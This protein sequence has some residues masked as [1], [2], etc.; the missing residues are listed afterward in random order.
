[1][2]GTTTVA[3]LSRRTYETLN[4][5]VYHAR[6]ANGLRLYVI[7]KPD[8]NEKYAVFA[9]R[10]GSIDTSFIPPGEEQVV[11]TPPGVA[12]FLE[13]KLFEGEDGSVFEQFAAL[14][15]S[16]NAYTTYGL[17][18]YL[19]STTDHFYQCLKTLVDFVQH[20]YFTDEN[21]AKE[22]GIIA[23]EIT[24]YEDN[25]NAQV[26]NNLLQAMYHHHPVRE[27]ITGSVQSVAGI[28][29]EILYQCHST[30]YH[31]ENMILFAIGNIDPEKAA[32]VV[33]NCFRADGQRVQGTIRRV[34]PSEPQGVK[35]S[36]I[37]AKMS[38]ARPLCYLGFK[39]AEL[40]S[41]DE[42]LKRQLATSLSLQILFGKTSALYNR[43]YESGLIDNSFSAYYTAEETFAYSILGGVTPDPVRLEEAVL[44]GLREARENGMTEEEFQRQKRKSIGGFL[45]ALNSLDFIA[46][47]F[48]ST[49][50]RGSSLFSYLD[51]LQE[52]KVE[53]VERCVEEQLTEERLSVSIIWPRP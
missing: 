33:E 23:Q 48:V 47:N 41:G 30:F 50:F 43:L 53:D 19:F 8:Y 36:R 32:Q 15:A 35:E 44:A 2:K 1:M 45:Y 6:L 39:D 24:M 51:I 42:L 46:N 31:P 52:L 38:V 37:E 26:Y 4:E 18:S 40:L 25:P 11:I 3:Q 22:Q 13:H 49:R 34:Y 16:V 12:H 17:T 29:P 28:T 27:K 14:G 5:T 9:T 7:P 20:P 21:V 10:Y